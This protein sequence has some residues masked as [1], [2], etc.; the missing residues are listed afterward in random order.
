MVKKKTYYFAEISLNKIS[1]KKH[2]PNCFLSPVINFLQSFHY[3]ILLSLQQGFYKAIPVTK[4]PFTNANLHF[5][6][7]AFCLLSKDG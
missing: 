7:L 2:L 1:I 4:N 5:E 3:I 6:R